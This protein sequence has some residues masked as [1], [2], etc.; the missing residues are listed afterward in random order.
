MSSPFNSQH[1]PVFG[2]PPRPIQSYQPPSRRPR[3]H[4][5]SSKLKDQ[6]NQRPELR[7][8]R[9]RQNHQPLADAS[10]MTSLHYNS[11][12]S[13]N[14]KL[15]S[16]PSFVTCHPTP[17]PSFTQATRTDTIRNSRVVNID[18]APSHLPYLQPLRTVQLPQ[19]PQSRLYRPTDSDQTANLTPKTR[20]KLAV[21]GMRKAVSDAALRK[22]GI[23]G[24]FGWGQ[25]AL[26]QPIIFNTEKQSPIEVDTEK[27]TATPAGPI[28]PKSDRD[29]DA[30][31]PSYSPRQY[32]PKPLLLPCKLARSSNP[33]R[34]PPPS[35]GPLFSRQ[36][37]ISYHTSCSPRETGAQ[38]QPDSSM[39]D[40]GSN[41]V[42]VLA[43][44]EELAKSNPR[45]STVIED[46]S[47]T[48]SD[49]SFTSDTD[50]H[51]ESAI[52]TPVDGGSTTPCDSSFASDH[53]IQSPTKGTRFQSPDRS[54]EDVSSFEV[55]ETDENVHTRP[56]ILD[57]L[58]WTIAA[59]RRRPQDP[60]RKALSNSDHP[61]RKSL[62]YWLG[63]NLPYAEPTRHHRSSSEI[64]LVR[65]NIPLNDQPMPTGSAHT[66]EI[67]WDRDQSA[68]GTKGTPSNWN[69]APVVFDHSEASHS[70]SPDKN[71]G[72]MDISGLS[73]NPIAHP[74]FILPAPDTQKGLLTNL[75]HLASPPSLWSPLLRR[76]PSFS[77]THQH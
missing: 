56:K 3:P 36:R 6:E 30:Q 34:S 28:S 16:K 10:N 32:T 48:P 66:H 46:G 7:A 59:P 76:I 65:R 42:D 74:T 64:V 45:C 69:E 17:Q 2:L 1:P 54:A 39:S 44:A 5:K 55:S 25:D 21:E 50:M 68:C 70:A 75:R 29:S 12:P 71:D 72:L 61:H 24:G 18:I 52:L 19:A 9:V 13:L 11:T 47:T 14:W 27:P 37:T 60:R 8:P 26:D 38:N 35:K 20:R 49:C 43:R 31:H 62:G 33:P 40:D 4:K 23:H 63:A 15:P 41:L 57:A 53:V 77:F 73:D 22:M 51:S 58:A 67:C